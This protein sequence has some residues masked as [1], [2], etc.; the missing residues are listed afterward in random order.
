MDTSMLFLNFDLTPLFQKF[1]RLVTFVTSHESDST[2]R[3]KPCLFKVISQ[4][5]FLSR[6][7]S[8]S[9]ANIDLKHDYNNNNIM[10][11]RQQHHE[12]R[13]TI[14]T[15]TITTSCP[16]ALTISCSQHVVESFTDSKCDWD[17]ST[18]GESA[19][20]KLRSVHGLFWAS[21]T[22]KQFLE[23]DRPS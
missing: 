20:S 17:N 22:C 23:S 6:F 8:D 19:L 7:D 9:K 13:T 18:S 12:T 15:T 4:Q 10:L 11:S 2:P 21:C 14:T 3:L 16:C 1:N 5:C